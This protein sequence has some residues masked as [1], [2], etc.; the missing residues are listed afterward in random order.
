[1]KDDDD[2]DD[3]VQDGRPRAEAAQ[4]RPPWHKRWPG[5]TSGPEKNT[6]FTL[7]LMIAIRI[8]KQIESELH[9]AP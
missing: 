1:M 8:I 6:V 9:V 5:Q 3:H 7:G 4:H 2:G